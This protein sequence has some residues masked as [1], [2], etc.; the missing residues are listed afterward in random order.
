MAAKDKNETVAIL[1]KSVSVSKELEA[2]VKEHETILK[3][4]KQPNELDSGE[5]CWQMKSVKNGINKYLG[6][7]EEDYKLEAMFTEKKEQ[8]INQ[9]LDSLRRGMQHVEVRTVGGG[10]WG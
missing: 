5:L 1:Q 2:L 9:A 6:L 3:D 8:A 4:L 7:S 10:E